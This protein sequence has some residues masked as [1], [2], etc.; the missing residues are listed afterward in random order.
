MKLKKANAIFGLLTIA[1]LLVHAGYQ[2]Y[3]F[4]M[5]VYNPGVTKVLG[6]LILIALILHMILGMS[7]MMFA[8][9]GSELKKYPK[10][11]KDTILQRVSAI[12]ILVFLFGHLNAYEILTSHFGGVLSLIIALLIQAL[13]FGCAF[14]HVGT[15]FSRA[16]VTLGLLESMETKKKIDLVV[17]VLLVILFIAI[18]IVLTQTYIALWSN[19]S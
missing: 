4:I 18:M 12:G 9:D 7:I 2:M 8:N 16:F 17:K 1:M 5:F 19:P 11:N 13:F 15:S 6:A 10:E 14:I 3:A